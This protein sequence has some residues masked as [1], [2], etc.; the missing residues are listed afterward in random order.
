MRCRF[1]PFEP[2]R[3]GVCAACLRERLEAVVAE[4]ERLGTPSSAERCSSATDTSCSEQLPFSFPRSVSPYVSRRDRES[5]FFSTPQLNA[6]RTTSKKKR[7][8]YRNPDPA[9]K[10]E[11]R[12]SFLSAIFGGRPER[13]KPRDD[14]PRVS[15]SWLSLILP[16]RHK[17]SRLFPA[18][19]G[20]T[21]CRRRDC[22]MSPVAR[23]GDGDESG[24]DAG[25]FSDSAG[26]RR[27]PEA[28]TTAVTTTFP[29]ARRRIL[30]H[31]PSGFAFCLSPL[32]R[33][34]PKG[35]H[36]ESA[37]RDRAPYSP[38]IRVSLQGKYLSC[39]RSRKLSDFGKFP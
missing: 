16:V 12:F 26:V 27:T 13:E 29:G 17:K 39:N 20:R 1:H 37:G 32:M 11:K 6:S 18:G 3:V 14:P 28:I 19:G 30:Q 23:E 2:G 22:G 5:L 21:A 7:S 25:Y 10:K 36:Q 8:K 24:D 38:E 9:L 4:R 33:P 15:S 34:C 35:R 31:N